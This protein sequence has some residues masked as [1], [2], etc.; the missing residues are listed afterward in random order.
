MGYYVACARILELSYLIPIL[1][2]S[3]FKT[4][5]LKMS[6]IRHRDFLIKYTKIFFKS[7]LFL[8]FIVI[9]F[10]E[11]ILAILYNENIANHHRLLQI[12]ILSLIPNSFLILYNSYYMRNNL[13]LILLIFSLL[14]LLFNL[15]FNILL[16]P[17]IGTIGAASSSLIS[18][19]LAIF[20]M[21][22][23]SIKTKF[24]PQSMVK[25]FYA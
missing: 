6:F 10:S 2:L 18:F 19:S 23:F 24:I 12:L 13:Q 3:S 17:Y 8:C 16:I 20:V 22:W 15:L 5:I 7:S 4:V 14:T 25:S 1:F 9:I 21:P 11:N